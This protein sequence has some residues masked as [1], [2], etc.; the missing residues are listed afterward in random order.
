ANMKVFQPTLSPTKLT[1]RMLRAAGKTFAVAAT[2][3]KIMTRKESMRTRTMLSVKLRNPL[4]VPFE[5]VGGRLRVQ[6]AGETLATADIPSS[7]RGYLIDGEK[8]AEMRLSLRAEHQ[9]LA[10]VVGQLDA[11]LVATEFK[12]SSNP[13]T[14]V[15]DLNVLPPEGSSLGGI[16]KMKVRFTLSGDNLSL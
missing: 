16:R 3:A 11:L 4:G 9:D 1:K 6:R 13:I 2:A 14:L 5:V 15:G 10:A 7:A 8:T 12:S